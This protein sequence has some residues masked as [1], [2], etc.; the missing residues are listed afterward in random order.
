VRDLLRHHLGGRAVRL[1]G[2]SVSGL[3]PAAAGSGY[4][5]HHDRKHQRVLSTVD[6]LRDRFGARVLVRARILGSHGRRLDRQAFRRR[7]P[8]QL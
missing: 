6:R 4:L 5:F 1:V 8:R 2:V 7:G 3:T